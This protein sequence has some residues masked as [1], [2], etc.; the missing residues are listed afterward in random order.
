MM[1]LVL[2]GVLSLGNIRD[3]EKACD[4]I[5]EQALRSRRS[6][7]TPSE[8]EEVVAFLIG[9]TWALWLRYDPLLAPTFGMFAYPQLRMR[10]LDWWRRKAGRQRPGRDAKDNPGEWGIGSTDALDAGELERVLGSGRRDDPADRLPTF[11]GLQPAGGGE[12]RG[13]V[14]ARRGVAS[15]RAT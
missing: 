12:A 2:N 4:S 14:G 10:M 9:E 15:R 7:L 5:V 11:S 1:R 3:V 8:R 13:L 6:R